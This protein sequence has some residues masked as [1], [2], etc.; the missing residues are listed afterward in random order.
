MFSKIGKAIGEDPGFT[1]S[2]QTPAVKKDAAEILYPN[3]AKGA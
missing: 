1:S 2:E 3:Q